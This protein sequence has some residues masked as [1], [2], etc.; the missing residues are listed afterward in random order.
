MCLF[1]GGESKFWWVL[2]KVENLMKG[3][4]LNVCIVIFNVMLVL[5][6]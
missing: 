2:K 4:K 6:V 5:E 3:V 1:W